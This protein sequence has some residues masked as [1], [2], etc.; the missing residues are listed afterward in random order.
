VGHKDKEGSSERNADF[1]SDS[2]NSREDAMEQ[3]FD[4][5]DDD[6]DDGD[7]GD[8]DENGMLIVHSQDGDAD[9][10][11]I[12]PPPSPTWYSL[13]SLSPCP[14]H[15]LHAEPTP[16]PSADSA[17]PA[18]TTPQL[19]PQPSLQASVCPLE[20]T[21]TVHH[22]ST[23]LPPELSLES[24]TAPPES[25]MQ[26]LESITR[27][28]DVTQPP[29]STMLQAAM[30]AVPPRPLVPPSPPHAVQP[31][32][33]TTQPPKSTVTQAALP[34]VP[35]SPLYAVPEPAVST[36]GRRLRKANILSLNMCTCGVT[37]TDSEIDAGINIMKCRVLGC[38]TVWVR[39]SASALFLRFFPVLTCLHTH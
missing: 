16:P 2:G 35:P 34:A 4:D 25:S 14:T 5:D 18:P 10:Y 22:G 7:D 8:D 17:H 6:G 15:T 21:A 27:P 24:N 36:R 1:Q 9:S 19:L 31:S 32:D 29:G 23:M 11:L 33:L 39:S 3:E 30:P 28:S 26:A 38:E 20:S 37:I 13:P 12:A